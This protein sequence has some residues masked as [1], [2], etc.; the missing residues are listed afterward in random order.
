[1]LING[2][3]APAEKLSEPIELSAIG[4]WDPHPRRNGST[5]TRRESRKGGARHHLL[6]PQTFVVINTFLVCR[7]RRVWACLSRASTKDESSGTQNSRQPSIDGRENIS[8]R[9]FFFE[10]SFGGATCRRSLIGVFGDS[11]RAS[12][13]G[14]PA[15]DLLTLRES[16][17]A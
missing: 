6:S 11:T 14:V 10:E 15:A 16:S 17:E 8:F 3:F 12:F 1:M 5:A 9:G 4:C 7:S 13:T 2:D